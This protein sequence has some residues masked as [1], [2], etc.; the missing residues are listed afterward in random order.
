MSNFS[1]DPQAFSLENCLF[2]PA[3]VI[4]PIDLGRILEWP[5][6]LFPPLPPEMLPTYMA[7]FVA[8]QNQENF[9]PTPDQLTDIA[10]WGLVRL[11]VNPLE[12]ADEQMLCCFLDQCSESQLSI[13]ASKIDMDVPN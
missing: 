10:L 3:T 11:S 2:P 13:I 1:Y 8:F 4:E 5:M 9:I 6:G 7:S 12:E